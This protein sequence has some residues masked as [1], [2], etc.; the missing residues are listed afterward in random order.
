MKTHTMHGQRDGIRLNE[1]QYK[2][3]LTQRES[4]QIG[5]NPTQIELGCSRLI[6]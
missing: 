6:D 5:F 4:F 3:I 2:I 1:Q